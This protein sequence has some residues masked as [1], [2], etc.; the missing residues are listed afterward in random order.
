RGA[1]A[2]GSS[3]DEASAEG[4]NARCL[5]PVATHPHPVA[6]A[7]DPAAGVPDR[8]AIR[9]HTDHFDAGSGGNEGDARSARGAEKRDCQYRDCDD[10]FHGQQT[11]EVRGVLTALTS[12]SP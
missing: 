7:A 1:P 4:I 10:L 2:P 6:T 12:P 3:G 5:P 9:G 11:R 8:T